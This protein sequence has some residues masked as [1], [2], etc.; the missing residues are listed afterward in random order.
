MVVFYSPIP[1]ERPPASYV[2]TV[3]QINVYQGDFFFRAKFQ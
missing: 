1:E 2:F 3:F